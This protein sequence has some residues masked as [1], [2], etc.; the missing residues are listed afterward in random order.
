[1]SDSPQP[2]DRPA[3]SATADERSRQLALIIDSSDDAIIGKSMDGIIT[4]WNVGA[5]RMYG[6]LREEAIGRPI[7]IVVPPD[8][9]NE[10]PRILEE[11]RRG[12]RIDHYETVRR[13]KDGSRIEVSVSVSPILD[14][15][16]HLLGAASIARDITDRRRG[17]AAL[18]ESEE[19]FRLL[20]DSAAE[21]IYGI[22]LEGSCT[23]CNDAC[24]QQLGYD[25]AEDLLGRNMHQLIHHARADGSALPLDD[26]WIFQAFRQGVNSHVVEEVLW[27]A[28][29]TSFPVEYWSYPQRRA[30]E[31][32][33]AV[34]TFID[35]TEHLRAEQEL[36]TQKR[37]LEDIITGTNV[38][39]WEWDIQT[40]ACAFNERWAEI[41]GY[42]SA[43]L[44]PFTIDTWWQLVHPEDE[45]IS[46]DALERHFHGETEHYECVVRLHHK[47]GG[48]VWV[49]DRGKVARWGP[50]GQP[51]FMSGMHHDITG[52]KEAEAERERLVEDLRTAL[53]EV[54]TLS[55]L[56][57]ICASCKKIRD[58]SGYWNILEAYLSEHSEARFSHGICPECEAKLL[59]AYDPD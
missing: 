12:R 36:A 23:F 54:K 15:R 44:Q 34:V 41:V 43:E 25:R 24:V 26:C 45:Q 18:R 13:R 29:G 16:G 42:T 50:D 49:L 39:T 3:G 10:M 28:D 20:L 1:M 4:S 22:D 35:I 46:R 53:A 27:R 5:E 38:G 8:R 17:E 31:I 57:P 32:V 21:A 9:P 30:G 6:W 7:S 33:G 52:R 2:T 58:D 14:Q 11:I 59:R 37:R 51:L 47:N 40:G 56:I 19:R 48:W 55:G